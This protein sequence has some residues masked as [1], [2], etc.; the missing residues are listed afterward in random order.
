MTSSRQIEANRPNGLRRSGPKTEAGQVGVALQCRCAMDSHQRQSLQRWN[1]PKEF[2]EPNT[3]G[4][5]CLCG[6]GTDPIDV[7]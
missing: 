7:I 6:H 4:L 2:E 3:A 5:E 1:T